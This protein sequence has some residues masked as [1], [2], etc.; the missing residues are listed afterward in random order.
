MFFYGTAE[1]RETQQTKTLT[2][3]GKLQ[4]YGPLSLSW[5]SIASFPLKSNSRVGENGKHGRLHPHWSSATSDTCFG[6]LQKLGDCSELKFISIVGRDYKYSERHLQIDIVKC[7][8]THSLST[9]KTPAAASLLGRI[10]TFFKLHLPCFQNRL[11][12]GLG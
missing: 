5:G 2:R 1:S 6:E 3:A 7:L 9:V 10:G 8:H 4:K 12:S 11:A